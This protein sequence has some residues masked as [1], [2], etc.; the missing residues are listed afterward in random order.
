MRREVEEHNKFKEE[1]TDYVGELRARAGDK[2]LDEFSALRKFSRETIEKQKIFYVGDSVE[3]LMPKYMDK[4]E[5]F[6]VIS[7]TNNKPIFH[8][9]FIIPIM[10]TD[11]KVINL[12]GYNREAD[13]R[14]LYGTAKYYERRDT[15]FGLENLHKAYE[16]GYAIIT[17][18]ITDAI[19]CRNIG[20][21]VAFGNCGTHSQ[22]VGI[23]QLNRCR[24]GIIK[25]PDRDEA[26]AKAEKKWNLLRSVKINTFIQYKD[27]DEMCRDSEDNVEIVKAYI[28]EAINYLKHREK[29]NNNCGTEK[30]WTIVQAV[31]S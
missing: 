7:P 2:R 17:E 6:G 26:G 31:K 10:D 27:I 5:E 16:L 1:L 30:E 19:M 22:T 29:S 14:Y 20:Y 15:L 25:I 11:G 21:D 28:D 12:V 23:R 24:Y 8:N 9:R 18:G 3:M 4:L 13:E